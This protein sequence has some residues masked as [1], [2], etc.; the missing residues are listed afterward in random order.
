MTIANI[1]ASSFEL[2][3]KLE[4]EEEQRILGKFKFA[5]NEAVLHVDP[6]VASS[7]IVCLGLN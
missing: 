4:A 1:L 6:R 3:N 7:P 5:Q 2:Q